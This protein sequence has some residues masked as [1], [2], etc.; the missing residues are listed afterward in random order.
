MTDI[1]FEKLT[2]EEIGFLTSGC[3]PDTIA[4]A[5]PELCFTSAC[6]RHD[7]AYW[8]GGT[9]SDRKVADDKFLRNMLD[10]ADLYL[11]WKRWAKKSAA[12]TYYYSVRALGWTTWHYGK[13]RTYEDLLNAMG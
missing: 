13:K 2:H 4:W 1:V 6:E 5:I 3:G 8:V 12:Y 7:V 9:S 10:I 11:F